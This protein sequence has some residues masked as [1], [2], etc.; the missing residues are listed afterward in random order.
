MAK[1]R[2]PKWGFENIVDSGSCPVTE[3]DVRNI[4][5]NLEI[6]LNE[7]LVAAVLE[8]SRWYLADREV[9][10]KLPRPSEVKPAIEEVHNRGKQFAE[11]LERLDFISRNELTS[12][13]QHGMVITNTQRMVR[14]ICQAAE[15]VLEGLPADRGGR[16]KEL[17]IRVFIQRL[18][19][20]YEKATGRNPSVTWHEHRGAFEGQ[21]YEF[22]SKLLNEVD[23]EY[24]KEIANNTALGQ[25][26]ISTLKYDNKFL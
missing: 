21:F 26:I 8:A 3:E 5:K 15:E 14:M 1:R 24:W 6:S 11:A 16:P 20:V 7:D 2:N 17:A 19:Q 9:L 25:K 12:R 4:G 13:F 10:D 23:G 22:V 18:A